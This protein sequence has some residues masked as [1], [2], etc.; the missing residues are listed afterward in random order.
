MELINLQK[1]L[2]KEILLSERLKAILLAVFSLAAA[3]VLTLVNLIFRRDLEQ[4]LFKSEYVFIIVAICFV[5]LIREII[6]IKY[7]NRKLKAGED[8]SDRVRYITNFIEISLPSVILFSIG[9]FLKTTEVLVS[10]VIFFYFIFIILSTLSLEFKISAVMGVIGA[11]E[12]LIVY[13]ILSENFESNTRNIVFNSPLFH[14]GKANLL[15]VGGIISGFVAEQIKKRMIRVNKAAIERNKIVNMFGQQVSSSIVDHLLES[16][17]EIK[18]ER[19]YVCIMFLDIRGFTHIAETKEPEEIVQF[20]NDAFGFMIEIINRY[21][22]VINQFLG[23]G[24]MATF[25]A[26]VS[27]GND[28]QNAVDASLEIISELEKKNSNDELPGVRIGI[29]LHSGF[30]VAGNVG[31][32]RRKQYS[33]SGNTVILASRI[34]QLNKKYNSQLLVSKEVID[35]IQLKNIGPKYHGKVDVKGRAEPIEIFQII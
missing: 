9:Y 12:Y 34:E 17:D 1:Q 21:K 33:I 20:Q 8:V 31:T 15:I 27:S 5:F 30:V 35:N 3:V 10:P 6:V 14:F 18:S 24:Y 25:G 22:G 23:D 4:Y 7:I 11:I 2:R 29:G 16:E 19:R 28:S 13:Y 32:E 26:P